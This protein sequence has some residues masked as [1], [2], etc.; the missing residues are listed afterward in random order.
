MSV[1]AASCAADAN[2]TDEMCVIS[3]PGEHHPFEYEVVTWLEIVCR[4]FFRVGG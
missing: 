3:L 4:A 1:D 2:E